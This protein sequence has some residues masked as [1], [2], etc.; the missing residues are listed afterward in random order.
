MLLYALLVGYLSLR[1]DSGGQG[2]LVEPWDKAAH[3]VTYAVFALLAWQARG[4]ALPFGALC[5]AIAVYSALLEVGQSFIPGR[6]LS[7]ADFIANV[8]GICG[9]A[10]L[11]LWREREFSTDDQ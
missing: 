9:M 2:L 7:G 1:P 3:F 5:L 6:Q 10:G 4:V 8:L 11:L